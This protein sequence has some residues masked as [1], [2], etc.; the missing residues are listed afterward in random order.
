MLTVFKPPIII[1]KYLPVSCFVN[2][3]LKAA[4]WLGPRPGRKLQM[5][6]AITE[7]KIADK[8]LLAS[9]SGVVIDC[10]GRSVSDFKLKIKEE[11]PNKPEKR[12]NNGSLTGKFRVAMPNAPDNKKVINAKS[13]DF[14]SFRIRI[15]QE[16]I[17]M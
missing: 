8:P 17:K 7:R 12:G 15:M 5:Q 1:R 4:A 3:E 14:F 11:I 6:P 16:I 2:D 9:I 13:F 10:G